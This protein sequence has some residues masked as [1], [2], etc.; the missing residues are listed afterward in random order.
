MKRVSLVLLVLLLAPAGSAPGAG[1][2]LSDVSG[3]PR[4]SAVVSLTRGLVRLK[5]ASLAPLP[6]P[7]DTGSGTF[8]AHEYKAYIYSAADPAVEIFLGDVYPNGKQKATLKVGM[9]GDLSRLGLDRV[10]VTAYSKDAQQSF[11]VLAADLVP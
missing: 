9:R 6:A 4:G 8:T 11:D 3:N 7:V 5:I 1:I 10:V 2:P